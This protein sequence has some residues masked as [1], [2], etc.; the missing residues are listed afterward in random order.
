MA[1]LRALDLI[2][3][4]VVEGMAK[5]GIIDEKALIDC[6]ECD[7]PCCIFL[8]H[9]LLK[10]RYVMQVR[11]QILILAYAIAV[12]RI[13]EGLL[14]RFSARML[15]TKYDVAREQDPAKI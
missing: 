11:Q 3:H 15:L 2:A 8:P 9:W 10:S 5:N 1:G 13:F 14:A 4:K 6:H 7:S 12:R